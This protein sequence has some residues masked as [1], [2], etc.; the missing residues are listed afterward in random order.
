MKHKAIFRPKL[1]P[2][3]I[4][5]TASLLDAPLDAVVLP[6]PPS[7]SA[8]FDGLIPAAAEEGALEVGEEEDAVAGLAGA[9]GAAQAVHVLRLVAGHADLDV[10]NGR[11]RVIIPGL[12]ASSL[13]S[14]NHSRR[15]RGANITA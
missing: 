8:V 7:G 3:C 6:R 5:R 9:G 11:H 1:K 14:C 2:K 4:Y 13:A 10:V 15:F 12:S